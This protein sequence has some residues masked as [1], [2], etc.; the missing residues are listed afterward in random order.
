MNNITRFL[1]LYKGFESWAKDTYDVQTM[2]DLERQEDYPGLSKY[3]SKLSF[4]RNLRNLLTHNNVMFGPNNEAV[5][6]ITNI[7]IDDFKNL[8]NELK[9]PIISLAL[10]VFSICKRTKAD[11][12]FEAMGIMN[13]NDYSHI[14][15]MENGRVIGVFSENTLFKMSCC[16]QIVSPDT[17]FADLVPYIKVKESNDSVYLFVPADMTVPDALSLFQNAN[18]EKRRLDILFITGDGTSQG[19]LKGMITAWDMVAV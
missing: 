5:L 8:Y 15:I 18:N 2:Q 10:D 16:S 12:V 9:L 13:N 7:L 3:R 17:T 11:N 4:Y 6:K 1:D 19:V 14:P